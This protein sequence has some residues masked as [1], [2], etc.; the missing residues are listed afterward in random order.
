MLR[1][2]N[3]GPCGSHLS[4]LNE[5]HIPGLPYGKQTLPLG[6]KVASVLFEASQATVGRPGC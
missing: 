6:V 5:C 4:E 3:L 1:S 2:L